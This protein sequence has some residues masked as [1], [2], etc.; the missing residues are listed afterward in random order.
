MKKKI[1]AIYI[2][3]PHSIYGYGEEQL[4]IMGLFENRFERHDDLQVDLVDYDNIPNSSLFTV[5]IIL[6][7]EA[8]LIK[9]TQEINFK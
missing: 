2:H 3:Q 5:K 1:S 8:E 9:K 7:S 4:T 6:K